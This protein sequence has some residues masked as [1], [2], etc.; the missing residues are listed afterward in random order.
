MDQRSNF[1]PFITTVRLH[2]IQ[3]SKVKGVPSTSAKIKKNMI[4]G[5]YKRDEHVVQDKDLLLKLR[6]YTGTVEEFKY[7]R[8]EDQEKLLEKFKQ[9]KK[10]IFKRS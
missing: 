9:G 3:Y 5:P 6:N 7:Q 8:G 1:C 2:E 10:I 4:R